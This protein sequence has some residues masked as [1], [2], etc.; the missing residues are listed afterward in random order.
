[1]SFFDD[2]DGYVIFEPSDEEECESSDD[3][4]E[5]DWEYLFRESNR[6]EKTAKQKRN[7]E[8]DEFEK[9]MNLELTN[10]MDNLHASNKLLALPGTAKG[11]TSQRNAEKTEEEK[12]YYDEI[13]FDSD[14]EG[15]EDSTGKNKKKKHKHP[16]ISNDDLFYDPNMDQTDQDWVDK[17][18]QSYKPKENTKN[19]KKMANSDAVLNC[20]ACM[21]TLC[22]DC[23]RHDTYKGQ[24]RAMFVLSCKVDLN[25][26]LR[27]PATDKKRKFKPTSCSPNEANP[28]EDIYHPVQCS[29][30][31]TEVAVQDKDEVY[32]FFNV[33]TGFA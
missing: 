24:Y 1:M 19:E 14:N 20:P 28:D 15:E 3:N 32:H 10:T 21:S 16:I 22:L 8:A 23:Q 5:F 13:Y 30:C 27:Y 6:G 9:E 12:K 26:V 17:R 25:K 4:D 31:N 18:R 33:L 11:E 29:I 2:D 7:I